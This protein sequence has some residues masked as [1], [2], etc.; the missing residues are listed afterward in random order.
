MGHQQGF[1]IG[2]SRRGRL[3]E[4]FSDHFLIVDHSEL[5][6]QLVA[7]GEPRGADPVFIAVVLRKSLR[8]AQV[9]SESISQNPSQKCIGSHVEAPKGYW[10]NGSGLAFEGCQP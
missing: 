8:D 10:I 3:I 1:V 6:M 9:S 2:V 4:G 7:A 5:V